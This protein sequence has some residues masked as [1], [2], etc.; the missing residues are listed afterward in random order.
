MDDALKFLVLVIVTLSLFGTVVGVGYYYLVELPRQQALSAPSNG[1]LGCASCM[2][3]CTIME[4]RSS[5]ECETGEC[6]WVCV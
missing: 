3:Y 1:A 6:A 2:A 4:H 5:D